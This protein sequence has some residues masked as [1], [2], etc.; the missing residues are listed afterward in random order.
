LIGPIPNAQSALAPPAEALTGTSHTGTSIT[1]TRHAETPVYTDN[2]I[3]TSVTT[4]QY[5]DMGRLIRQTSSGEPDV[6]FT[7]DPVISE[8]QYSGLDLNGD[9][10]LTLASEDRISY[11]TERF[12]KDATTGDW[13]IHSVAQTFPNLNDP[14]P[15]T[16]SESYLRV[17]GHA[18][19]QIAE[20]ILIDAQG[21][22]T[23]SSSVL[24][25]GNRT[26]TV[27]T[28]LPDSDTP[29]QTTIVAGSVRC[30]NGDRPSPR[31]TGDG[32]RVSNPP[33]D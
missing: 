25:R 32:N 9:G 4:M 33:S 19:N 14:T 23:S 5:D 27:T 7:Y 18:A 21:L 28:I 29:A 10:Q 26:T 20:S 24:T 1:G 16:L 22:T 17:T 31:E 6:L 3:E 2:Q 13:W 12:L 15:Q 11:G 8:L 30:A